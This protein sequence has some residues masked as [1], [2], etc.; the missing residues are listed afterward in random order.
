MYRALVSFFC[1]WL[2]HGVAA[3]PR[4]RQVNAPPSGICPQ[5]Q[6]VLLCAGGDERRYCMAGVTSARSSESF[7]GFNSRT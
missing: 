7:H 6:M 3:T 5:Q 1:G 4:R 2:R